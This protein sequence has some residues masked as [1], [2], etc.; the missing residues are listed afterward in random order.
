MLKKTISIILSLLLIITTLGNICVFAADNSDFGRD[1]KFDDFESYT[2]GDTFTWSKTSSKH[3]YHTFGSYSMTPEASEDVAHS[4]NKSLKVFSRCDKG[5][6]LKF[7]N[8]Y[9][10]TNENVGNT[11]DFSLWIY[12]DKNAGVYKN[13]AKSIGECTPFTEE[14]LSKSEGTFFDLIMAG[15]DG[16]NYQYRSGQG[17]I[18]GKYFVRWNT[19]TKINAQFTFTKSF[20]DNGSQEKGD[21]YAVNAFRLYQSGIDYSLNSGLCD[22]FYVDDVTVETTGASVSASGTNPENTD[23]SVEVKYYKP[24]KE[25]SVRAIACEY[26]EG[27]LI[28]IKSNENFIVKTNEKSYPVKDTFTMNRKS[29]NS[30]VRVYVVSSDFS[31][32]VCS[33]QIINLVPWSVLVGESVDA[34]T[35][36]VISLSTATYKDAIDEIPDID[37]N[38]YYHSSASSYTQSAE[39]DVV[40]FNNTLMVKNSCRT[41]IRF[42]LSDIP[43]KTAY[44]YLRM[45]NYKTSGTLDGGVIS[46]YETDNNW[47][48]DK[49][50]HNNAPKL[51]EKISELE[52]TDANIP[53]YF[54]IS[55]YMNKALKE[56]KTEYTFALCTTGNTYLSFYPERSTAVKYYKPALIL[57]GVGK[58]TSRYGIS[59]FE[60]DSFVD[61]LHTEKEESTDPN[62]KESVRVLS[63]LTDYTPKTEMPNLS[64]YGGW[65]DGGKYN[66][67]GFFRT[68]LID[69]R[70]W[71]IDPLGYKYI[72]MGVSCTSPSQKSDIQDTG[73]K[74]RYGTVDNWKNQVSDELRSYGFNGMGPWSDFATA[75]KADKPVN[76]AILKGSF[77]EGFDSWSDDG[78][79]SVF[80]PKFIERCESRAQEIIA[81]YSDNPYILGWYTDNE[82]PAGASMLKT[83][84]AKSSSVYDYAVAWKWFRMRKGENATVAD[85]TDEDKQDWI[86]FVYDRYMKVVTEAIRKVDKNHMIFGPKLDKNNRAMFRS[87]GRYAD[88][89]GYDYYPNAF[90]PDRMGVID[91]YKWSGKPLMNAEWYVKGLDACTTE[92]ELTN[93]SGVGYEVPT[94]RDRGYYYQAFVL[95]MLESR[96]FVGW[97][98]FRYTDNDPSVDADSSNIDAN[99]GIFTRDYK[100]YDDIVSMM[101]DININAYE[102]TKYMDK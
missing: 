35:D 18:I 82:P 56:G 53:C 71:F 38:K 51:G 47:Q 24:S 77:L 32:P 30:E 1:I 89:I 39:P 7:I 68:E 12:A 25:Y 5:V 10:A 64:Q 93:L 58:T 72:D 67:T 86:E 96:V 44:A 21:N 76:Q 74:N 22:T 11:Y 2:T 37:G 57:E 9:E 36:E 29:E 48:E 88:A 65:I 83:T 102:L 73:F 69:G 94:Q 46:V 78:V 61:V 70:W 85:I 100:V 19:W 101:K 60:G 43:D 91:W 50:T 87:V 80:S 8:L 52:V 17:S 92:S 90:T 34:Y 33:T 98:W 31:K 95:G 59:S 20:V 84:L 66:A 63:S 62:N 75:L 3:D 23:V 40:K 41:Y 26:L 79:M 42:N 14:E 97:Q 54:N 27:K 99:K 16:D 15:P 4:G 55:E 49:L 28:N 13:S 81:P 6:S 45:Y